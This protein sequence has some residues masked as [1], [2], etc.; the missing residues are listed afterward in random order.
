[1]SR[2]AVELRSHALIIEQRGRPKRARDGVLFPLIA[3]SQM[4]VCTQ[5]NSYST[6]AG[7]MTAAYVFLNF[8]KQ[9]A[10]RSQFRVDMSCLIGRLALVVDIGFIK[11]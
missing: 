2:F 5:G 11:H 1:M 4:D 6:T 8:T 7:F 9:Y 10:F 3:V